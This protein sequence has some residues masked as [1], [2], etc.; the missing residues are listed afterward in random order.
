MGSLGRPACQRGDLVSQRREEPN[1]R[2][3]ASFERNEGESARWPQVRKPTRLEQEIEELVEAREQQVAT[4][5]VLR[6]ISSSAGELEP[7]F[8]VILGN[9]TRICE[10]KFGM[11]YLWEGEGQ[12]SVAATVRCTAP[13]GG[14]TPPRS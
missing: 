6:I 3:Q 1:A 9:A 2:S 14:G 10:A 4:S 13:T 11:L 8:E 12:Y 7:V 5:E